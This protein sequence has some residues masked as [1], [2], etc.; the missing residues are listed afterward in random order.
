MNAS[1]STG[2]NPIKIVLNDKGQPVMPEAS[3]LATNLGVLARDGSLLPLHYTD[4]RYVPAHYKKRV[5]EEIKAH[6]DAND[7]M[8][9]CF[10]QSLGRKW[11]GWKCEAKKEGYTP[12]DNDADIIAHRP[13]R[14][15]E[16]HWRCLVYYCNDIDVKHPD[17][18][19][20][21]REMTVGNNQASPEEINL[22]HRSQPEPTPFPQPNQQADSHHQCKPGSTAAAD[23]AMWKQAEASRDA[24]KCACVV[25]VRLQKSQTR[26]EEHRKMVQIEFLWGIFVSVF[27]AFTLF[28]L[29][30]CSDHAVFWLPYCLIQLQIEPVSSRSCGWGLIH[31]KSLLTTFLFWQHLRFIEV[32]DGVESSGYLT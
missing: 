16:E 24:R 10:M 27:A 26:R 15:T 4:W 5:W 30:N 29:R 31:E 1:W 2:N 23:L 7:S 9:R 11:Q 18:S 20:A 28:E 14:V 13:S 6:T 8:E 25:Y 12:Y 22:A 32:K 3:S 17:A 21:H 19:S